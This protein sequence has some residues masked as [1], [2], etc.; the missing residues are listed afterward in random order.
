MQL[1]AQHVHAQDLLLAQVVVGRD[2]MDSNSPLGNTIFSK[3]G[4][5]R[6]GHK[7]EKK[8]VTMR[9]LANLV[10]KIIIE[11]SKERS[12]EKLCGGLRGRSERHGDVFDGADREP[13]IV[14]IHNSF[15]SM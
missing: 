13:P 11:G 10:K 4:N 8:T 9:S 1:E 15:G 2:S 5:T 12:G 6:S 3:A 14:L 7:M